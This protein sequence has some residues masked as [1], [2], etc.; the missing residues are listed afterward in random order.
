MC[1]GHAVQELWAREGAQ[2]GVSV[3]PVII[4]CFWRPSGLLSFRGVDEPV[5]ALLFGWLVI[6]IFLRQ[7]LTV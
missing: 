6:W 2:S 5:V 4:C 1:S 3:V 7:D